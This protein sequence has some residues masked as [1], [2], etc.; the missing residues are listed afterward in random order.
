M[1]Q[2]NINQ[3]FCIFPNLIA[4]SSHILIWDFELDVKNHYAMKRKIKQCHDG[5]QFQQYQPNGQLF[6]KYQTK[7]STISSIST[8]W[9]IISPISTK[10]STISPIST[11]WS[12][13][14]P[15][16]TKWSTISP[17]STKWSTILQISAKW[18]TISPILT[19]WSTILQIST[20]WSTISPIS[21]KWSTIL[22]I[23]TK[24]STILQISTKWLIIQPNLSPQI[25]WHKKKTMTC[26]DVNPLWY[27][28][29]FLDEFCM[30]NAYAT[31][32][33]F[34]WLINKKNVYW[35]ISICLLFIKYFNLLNCYPH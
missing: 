7:W 31:N 11:K 32:T 1:P 9:S 16:S 22:Q 33:H 19:K 14:S 5:Q 30:V 3:L 29:K 6:C 4:W 28:F 21:T 10:W 8:K 26:D 24:W 20:K 18:S 34:N 25:I 15:I 17:I 35:I 12:I 23:S 13:I 27:G 2:N